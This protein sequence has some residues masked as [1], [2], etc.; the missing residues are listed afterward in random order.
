MNKLDKKQTS[1]TPENWEEFR[2]ETLLFATEVC[3]MDRDTEIIRV[4]D[5]GGWGALAGA[6][7]GFIIAGLLLASFQIID[8][9]QTPPQNTFK[10]FAPWKSTRISPVTQVA[11]GPA[12]KPQKPAVVAPPPKP[13]EPKPVVVEEASK[14]EA[15]AKAAEEAAQAAAEAKAAKEADQAA[16]K[17]KATEEA[18][19]AAAEA[20][21][22]AEAAQ[23]AAEVKVA[24]EAAQAAAKAKAAEEARAAEEAKAAQAAAE[25]KA[26]E[27]A[28]AAQIAAKAKAAQA[29]IDI[30]NAVKSWADAW[31]GQKVDIY[32]NSYASDFKPQQYKSHKYWEAQRRKRLSK[33]SSISVQ[34]SNI[35]TSLAEDGTATVTFVQIYKSPTFSDNVRKTLQ[36]KLESDSWKIN[37]ETSKKL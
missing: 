29:K 16:A 7:V 18:A 37:N 9:I 30:I 25:A 8:T 3:M 20:K 27:E 17:A 5:T 33:P 13:P 12:M 24:E 14:A 15:E 28:E 26:A 1:S 31:S 11:I 6:I 23:A 4:G 10:D 35:Q 32:I 36:L 21:A 34:L 22:A 2:P 19:Q